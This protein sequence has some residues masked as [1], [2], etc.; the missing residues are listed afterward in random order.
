[1]KSLLF[2]LE[3]ILPLFVLIITGFILRKANL[4]N[5]NFVS[6]GTKVVFNVSLPVQLFLQISESDLS[7]GMNVRLI[8]FALASTAILIGILWFTVPKFVSGRAR[9]GTVIHTLFRGNFAVLGVPLAFSIFGE[10]EAAPSSLLLA[11]MIPFY[12]AAAVIILTV[13]SPEEGENRSIPVKK[14]FRGILTNPLIYGIALAVPFALTG[15][16]LPDVLT[17]CLEPV[18]ELTTPLALICLGGQFSFS[19][20]KEDLKIP[21]TVTLFKLVI[22]PAVMITI[23]VMLDFRGGELGAIFILFSAPTAVT[24]YVMAKNMH[25]DDV[26]AGQILVITTFLSCFTLCAIL[27]ILRSLRLL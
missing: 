6:I 19:F 15:I 23:A 25:S 13:F 21:L 22:I 18:S 27:F 20:S 17:S 11:F 1:M 7:G 5:E 12:N 4:I 10:T 3:C 24:S 2:C 16:R 26:L 9:Q 14:I 8:I